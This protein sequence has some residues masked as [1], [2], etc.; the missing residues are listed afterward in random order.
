MLINARGNT[1]NTSSFRI[2]KKTRHVFN[3]KNSIKCK[4]GRQK[5][6]VRYI[7]LFFQIKAVAASITS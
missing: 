4:S 7:N 3:D 5:F 2:V 6:L 1:A